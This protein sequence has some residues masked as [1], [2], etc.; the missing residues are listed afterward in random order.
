MKERYRINLLIPYL[1]GEYFG[2][3]FTTLHREITKRQSTLFTIQALA[4]VENPSAFD[5]QIGTQVTD[6]WLLVTNPNSVLPSSPSFL[7]SLKASGKPVVTIGYKE[8]SIPSHAVIIDNRQAIKEAVRH[9][10]EDHGHRRIAF[11]GGTEHVDLIDRYESYREA[12][13]EH[14]IPYE[15]KLYFQINNALRMGGESAA[16]M[17]LERGIDFTAVIAATDLNAMGVIDGLQAAGYRVPQDIAVIGFDDLPSAAT[18]QPPLTSVYQPVADLAKSSIDLLFRRLE[19]EA[20]PETEVY[21]PTVFRPRTSCGCSYQP[22]EEPIEVLQRKLAH[23]EE[24]LRHLIESHNQLAVNWAFASRGS[25]FDFS[26]MFQGISHWGCLAMWDK[27][28]AEQKKLII[29]QA[30]GRPGDPVPPVGLSIPIEQFPPVQWL[31]PIGEDEFVRVQ[32]IRS[33][34]ADLGFVVLVGPIDRLV[35][36]SEVDITRISCNVSVTALVR[37]QLFD[38]VQSI[39]EQLEIVSRTTNDGIWD[40]DMTTNQIQWS[41]RAHDMIQSIGE[42]LTN[43]PDSFFRLIHPEDYFH[44]MTNI[45]EHIDNDKP[46]RIE[47]RIQ[48][49]EEGQQLWLFIAGDSIRDQQG[50]KVR[51]IGSVTNITEKKQAEKE[52]SRL[53]YHDALTGLPNRRL[54]RK[55]FG[56][57]KERADRNKY[58]LGIMLIDLDRFKIINDTLGHHVGD[59]LLRE[60][61][62]MIERVVTSALPNSEMNTRVVARLG[63]DEF[64][65]LVENILTS[66]QLSEVAEQL[67]D[68]FQKPFIVD[69]LELY[70]TASIG[71]SVYPDD[72]ADIDTLTRCADI[73]MYKAK[74]QGKN[75]SVMYNQSIHS[76]TYDRLSM[77]NEL[78]KALE[79][80]EFVLYYQPQYNMESESVIGMEALIRWNSSERGMVPPNE[81]IPLAEESGLIISIGKWVLQ[82]A[83]SQMKQWIDMGIPA[84]LVSVNISA[85]QLS[86]NDFVDVVKSVLEKTK[87]P[88]ESLCLEITE[89]T[90]LMS[91]NNSIEKLHKLRELGVHI[92]LDDFGTGYSSLS[93]LKHLPITS[94]KIDRSF[95]RDMI[96]HPEDEAIASAT[97]SLANRLGLTVIAEGVETEEQRKKLLE[98]GCYCIQGYIYSKPLPSGACLAFIQK[99]SRMS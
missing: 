12:L 61:A 5:Y 32:F 81:F 79:R 20:V 73:A 69:D 55:R 41:N 86:Q 29:H 1:D 97:I 89:S 96:V 78:R 34:Q 92:A 63:G 51:L 91:L 49:K 6:G 18:F 53:A 14:G 98:E 8:P 48:G 74:E 54:F 44:V 21:I 59:L 95:V 16:E 4:S 35:L 87:L 15:D 68:R 19:G 36:V 65:V 17:M 27:K 13:H 60:V 94:V 66:E 99:D 45:R 42:T 77:E 47:C 2:T 80:N 72:G 64:I 22:E 56:V 33:D 93:M 31:P 28:D 11:V 83:C 25:H 50:Q 37:D 24:I 84:S 58:K 88:P 3:I 39:A 52:I 43:S 40:W 10:V 57:A 30:F 46:L 38:Q 82:E 75:Q 76:L 26:R 7:E 70:T 23:S 85:S 9:L 67:I 62:E 90:A 71:M